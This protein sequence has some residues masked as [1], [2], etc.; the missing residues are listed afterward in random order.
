[1]TAPGKV[2][3][4][5][6][7][8]HRAPEV[9][10]VLMAPDYDP[11]PECWS[12]L[13]GFL[14]GEGDGDLA[15]F[16]RDAVWQ[17]LEVDSA[18]VVDLGGSVKFPR[19][20]VLFA[21]QF[22]GAVRFLQDRAPG[23]HVIC[24]AAMAGHH[25]TAVAGDRGAARAGTYGNAIAGIQGVAMAGYMGT[26]TAGDHGTAISGDHGTAT[27]GRQGVATS[28]YHGKSV[29]GNHGTSATGKWGVAMAG[30]FGTLMIKRGDGVRERTEIAYVGE[31]GI[32]PNTPYWLDED[33]KFVEVVA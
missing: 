8:S 9:G 22:D 19:G 21:G 4:L 1:M 12:G 17:V 15:T 24:S 14:W 25:G 28:G 16:D 20:S 32:K 18:E 27:A 5:R 6:S 10:E 23:R 29:S 11:R 33:G 31:N 26:A 3:V 30:Q 13:R 7:G 2:L